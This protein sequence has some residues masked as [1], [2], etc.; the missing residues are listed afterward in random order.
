MLATELEPTLQS[1]NYYREQ[2][3]ENGYEADTQHIG[4][5]FKLAHTQPLLTDCVS[6][7]R[8]QR[9]EGSRW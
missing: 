1:F 5:L 3:H 7:A 2:A 9:V 6:Y 4:Y 8:S